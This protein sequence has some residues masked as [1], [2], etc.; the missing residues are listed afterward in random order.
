MNFNASKVIPLPFIN[1]PSNNQNTNYTAMKL[2]L[3]P[4][5]N[6]CTVFVASSPNGNIVVKLGGFQLLLSYL[7]CNSHTMVGSHAY[8]IAVQTHLLMHTA[9]AKLILDS[10]EISIEEKESVDDMMRDVVYKRASPKTIN[11]NKHLAFMQLKMKCEYNNSKENGPTATLWVK[12][13]RMLMIPFF[14]ASDN[15]LYMKVAL[16]YPQ[17]MLKL[18]YKIKWTSKMIEW[19]SNNQC[20]LCLIRRLCRSAL[21]FK[22]TAR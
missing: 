18:E 14:H 19:S 21:F 12:Y 7:G 22:G 8:S 4:Y 2:V 13:F 9:L 10:S 5:T 11:N 6:H 20:Y 1:L 16:L 3:S 17:G 15:F